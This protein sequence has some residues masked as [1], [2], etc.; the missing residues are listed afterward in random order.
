MNRYLISLFVL[1][2][3]SS[4]PIW[5]QTSTLGS[6]VSHE[7]ENGRVFIGGLTSFWTSPE[8]KESSF[9]IEPE[10]GYLFNET[11][12]IGTTLGYE[13]VSHDGKNSHLAVISP[14]VRYY[15]FHRNPFNLYLDGGVGWSASFEKD[16]AIRR[17]FEVGVRPGA[18][19]DLTEGL[20][21]CLRMGFVGYR[22][23]Y[24][25]GEEQG[26]GE[27]GFGFLFSPE[28]LSVGLELEF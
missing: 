17:G 1:F 28:E 15:Y 26:L 22:K 13:L 24:A 27:S 20:C 9:R 7:H 11:W 6:P 18:C 21:L 16:G 2:L 25:G 14:F 10:V 8:N 12:G 4:S 3:L 19:V 5:G 23:N